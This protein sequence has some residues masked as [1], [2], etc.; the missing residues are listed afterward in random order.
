MYGEHV[1]VSGGVCLVWVRTHKNLCVCARV[2][3]S[4]HAHFSVPEGL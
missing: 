4:M 2:C 3:K 1:C